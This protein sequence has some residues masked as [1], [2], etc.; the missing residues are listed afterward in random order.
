MSKLQNIF[1]L[2]AKSICPN[3][4]MRI[5]EWSR[6]TPLLSDIYQPAGDW[7]GS[8]SYSSLAFYPH[9]HLRLATHTLLHMAPRNTPCLKNPFL[10][11]EK[12]RLICYRKD[13]KGFKRYIFK[14]RIF[15]INTHSNTCSNTHSSIYSNT[16]SNIHSNTLSK[17][18]LPKNTLLGI[19]KNSKIIRIFWGVFQLEWAQLCS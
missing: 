3:R 13:I 19:G 11:F 4:K 10:E 9:K 1:V 18:T 7:P 6:S 15:L 12:Y 2:I 14:R 17:N 8:A 5:L 16:H